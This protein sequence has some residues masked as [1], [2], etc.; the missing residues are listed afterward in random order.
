M[1]GRSRFGQLRAIAASALVAA[2]FVSMQAPSAMAQGP[3]FVQGPWSCGPDQT[4][5][6]TF[7]VTGS[8]G[9]VAVEPIFYSS[10]YGDVLWQY[11]LHP[12]YYT[13]TP[14]NVLRTIYWFRW[15]NLDGNAAVTSWAKSCN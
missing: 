2:S 8:S 1:A 6:M 14:P 4:I 12:G 15:G 10:V 5:S 9:S 13:K 7:H 11:T 3:Y